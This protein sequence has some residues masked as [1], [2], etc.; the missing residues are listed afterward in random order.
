[1]SGRLYC[2]II[3]IASHDLLWSEPSSYFY[4]MVLVDSDQNKSVVILMK[5]LNTIAR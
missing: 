3:Y 2:R 5:T 4:I 1:M